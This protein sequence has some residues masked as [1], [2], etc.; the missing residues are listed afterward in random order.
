MMDEKNK[1]SAM[2]PILRVILIVTVVTIV[3]CGVCFASIFGFLNVLLAPA[4]DVAN[5]FLEAV[6]DDNYEIAYQQLSSDLKTQV[7][8]SQ[9]LHS[10]VLEYGAEPEV[11]F[12]NSQSVENNFGRFVGQATLKNGEQVDITI[13]LQLYDE[14]WQVTSFEWGTITSET[15]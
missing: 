9:R 14:L 13:R 15:F 3:G 4:S 12:F 6:R 11:W 2:K 1:P 10:L 7:E 8:D 5:T